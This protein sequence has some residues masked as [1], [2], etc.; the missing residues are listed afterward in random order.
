MGDFSVY[1]NNFNT[2]SNFSKFVLIYMLLFFI[3]FLVNFIGM[4]KIYKKL[5]KPGWAVIVPIYNMWA[6]FEGV[7]L[8]GWL[9]ILPVANFIGLIVA[10]F[11]LAKVLNKSTG[12]GLGLVFLSF[13]FIPILGFSDAKMSS[14][15]ENSVEGFDLMASDPNAGGELNLMT[16]DPVASVPTEAQSMAQPEA[17]TIDTTLTFEEQMSEPAPSVSPTFVPNEPVQEQV[18][19][20]VVPNINTEE[21]PTLVNDNIFAEPVQ[22]V[23]PVNNNPVPSEPEVINIF[24]EGNNAEVKPELPEKNPEEIFNSPSFENTIPIEKIS[25]PE[26]PSGDMEL[27]KLAS[28][29]VA[30]EIMGGTKICPNCGHENGASIK[31]C[32]KCG[33]LID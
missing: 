17:P 19:P 20:E 21:T 30:A 15:E 10:Y 7:G 24:E 13:I 29:D 25:N 1:V 12:F 32:L 9:S 22:E 23:K 11:R 18:Q 31:A 3:V 28:D 6:L 4:I 14:S 5:N 2:N 26:I 8:P 16:P 33:H 27:P